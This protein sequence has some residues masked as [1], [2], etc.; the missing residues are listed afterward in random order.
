MPS[1]D[2]SPASPS[3]FRPA[4]LLACVALLA[5]VALLALDLGS[6]AAKK[7]RRPP[8]GDHARQ[9][10]NILAPGEFGNVPPTRNS[11]DQGSLYDALTPLQG[12]VT[13]GDL[14]RLFKSERFGVSGRGTRKEATGR[15]GL[16]IVRDAFDVPHVFG[17][18]RDDV[19]FGA[20]WVAAE[21]RGLLLQQGRGPGYVSALSVPGVDAFGLIVNLQTF[22]PSPQAQAY[23]GGQARVLQGSAKGRRVLRDFRAWVDGINAYYRARVPA[24]SRPAPFTLADAFGIFSF[25]G[26]IFGNGGGDEV[27]SADLLAGLQNRLGATAG[28]GVW[29]DLRESNDPEA[30]TS[31][32]APFDYHS[33]PG[34]PTAGSPVIDAGSIS[35]MG[36]SA[37]RTLA[38]SRQRMSNAL[39]IAA[40]R[41]ASRHPLA[42]MGP[43]LGYYYPEI[44]MEAD[45][46]G[47]GIDARGAVAPVAPYVL[48]GRAKRYAWS[49]TSASNDNTDQFLE[50][51]CNP[52]GSPATSS[53]TSYMYKGRCTPMTSFDAGLLKGS[54]GQPDRELTFMQTVH[55]PVSGTVTVAGAPYA[56]ATDRATRGREPASA[57][58][59]ADLN[60]NH[61]TGP[62]SFF[63]VANEFETTFNWH[64]ADQRNIAYFSSG[65]LPVRAPGLNPDLPTLGTGAYDWRGF[66][67]QNAHPH[68]LNPPAGQILNWNNKPAPGWGAADNVWEYGSVHR[69]QEFTG[70]RRR[71]NRLSDVASVMNRAA[72][73]D[74]RA[75][76]VWPVVRRVLAGSP[77]PSPVAQQAADLVTAWSARGSSRLDTTGNGK[78]TDPGAAVLDAAW[79]GLADA[80]LGPVL[81]P[82]LL[83]QFARIYGRDNKPSPSGSAYGGGWYEYVD[84]DLRTQLGDPVRGPFSRRYCGGGDLTTCRNSLW[85]AIQA[86]ATQLSM[87]QGPDPNAWRAGAN[88]ERI[89]FKPGLIPFSMR[90]TNRP[91]FQQAIEFGR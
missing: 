32:P 49:L 44:V 26:S 61:A 23:V 37:A 28:A 57:L 10:Y 1:S 55:G 50:Q 86:A 41:S 46:H 2:P 59:L 71:G 87:T 84:K 11:T 91:T 18:T 56:I 83:S 58:A 15:K 39:L 22:I 34:G 78:V 47:G 82:P 16:R 25:I 5:A 51:L 30:P 81:G 12:N 54:S 53:S 69:V 4:P 63:R 8:F 73:Q 9:A 66:L 80:V 20:G 74:L 14:Q 76:R 88:P 62:T 40:R 6:A 68:A 24:A 38:S 35:P 36:K 21:D 89:T 67:S 3:R 42:V 48:I 27:R 33:D 7:P 19:S 85:A 79:P 77:A 29:H 65:R 60:A 17:R 90:W 13:A 45:L 75:V 72:T 31:A 52:D 64:Y 43:Q 70:F